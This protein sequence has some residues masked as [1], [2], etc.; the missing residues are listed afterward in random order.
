MNTILDSKPDVCLRNSNAMIKSAIDT[1]LIIFTR[2][3][4]S[5]IRERQNSVWVTPER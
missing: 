4:I 3:D 1:R 2:L 5:P